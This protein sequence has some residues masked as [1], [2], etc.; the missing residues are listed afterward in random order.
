MLVSAGA[1]GT[2]A[3][4]DA[5][6]G[7]LDIRLC[8]H[9]GAVNCV[10]VHPITSEVIASGGEDHSV[11]L[12]DLRDVDPSSAMAKLSREKSIGL[13]LPHYT[14]KGHEGGVAAVQ[15]TTDGQLLASAS[16]DCQ[17]RIWVPNLENPVL[18]KKFLAHEAWIRDLTWAYDQH[19]LFTCSTDGMVFAWDVPKKHH[20]KVGVAPKKGKKRY[21][22]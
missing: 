13:N 3:V 7:A 18:L 16:K 17:V 2:I 9:L 11:R 19:V 15:F 8:G 10:S 14:L 1:E 20:L 21:Q 22:N 12:W 6:V 5:E 4:W